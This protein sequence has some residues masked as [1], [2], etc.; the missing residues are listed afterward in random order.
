MKYYSWDRK[1]FQRQVKADENRSMAQ[2]S[3]SIFS[4]SGEVTV[5]VTINENA[6][7]ITLPLTSAKVLPS[8]YNI[9]C[10]IEN[11]NTIVFK[12]DRPEKVAVI[13]NYDEAWKVFEEKSEGHVPIRNFEEGHDR[14]KIGSD[15]KGDN[16]MNDLSE[17]YKNP[18]FIFALP[19]EENLPDKNSSTNPCG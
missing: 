15:F 2:H 12:L 14:S 13:A 1:I 18:V 10:W 11:G 7:H 8:S 4:F 6:K 5:R 3:T 9:P 17:G 16:L 19:P